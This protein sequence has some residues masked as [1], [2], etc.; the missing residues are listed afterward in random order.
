MKFG[1]SSVGDVERIRTAAELVVERLSLKPLVVVSAVGSSP[2]PGGEKRK[3]VTDLLV[4]AARKAVAGDPLSGFQEIAERHYEVLDDLEIE[5]G[6]IDGE[7]AELNELLRGIFLVKELTLRTLDY[8]MSFGERILGK[9]LAAE[10]RKRGVDAVAL[11]S[12]DLGFLTDGRFGA[13]RP[14]ADCPGRISEAVAARD[15]DLIVTTGFIGKNAAGEIT[16][17]GRGGSDYTASYFAAALGAE[18]VQIWTDVDGVLTADPTLI[19]EAHS[20]DRMSFRE[21]AEL[22]YYGA[23]VLHPATMIPAIEK[24]IPIRVLNTFSPESG[25]TV[26]LPDIEAEPAR[27]K[28]IV[29]K[30]DL[31]LINVTSTRMLGQAGFMAELFDVFRRH[32]VVIDMIATSE[33]SLSLTTDCV[34]HV[35]AAAEE[36]RKSAVADVFVEHGKSIVCVVG[37]GMRHVIGTAARV[38]GTVAAAGANIEMI[39]QGAN[40]INIAFLVGNDDMPKVVLGLHREFFPDA[41]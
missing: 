16:T 9:I 27:V 24:G 14:L 35:E 36:L 17:V 31:T 41:H 23:Q 3:K 2:G 21:A 15:E 30:E 10:L 26:I 18:E 13:A 22:A 8:A 37:S 25:G 11:A 39:S 32:G 38:F 6:L 20:I 40:E 5:R 12:Y 1:G 7:L 4:G 29:Y 28:A 33:V 34:E 19:E